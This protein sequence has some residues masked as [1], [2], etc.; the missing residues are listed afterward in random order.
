MKSLNIVSLKSFLVISVLS[1]VFLFTTSLN[2]QLTDASSPD[3]PTMVSYSFSGLLELDMGD[4]RICNP[5]N[6]P[7]I[8]SF[9]TLGFKIDGS[10]APDTFVPQQGAVY[11][12]SG[13]DVDF[14]I[15]SQR[16]SVTE[17]TL[18]LG[19]NTMKLYMEQFDKLVFTFMWDNQNRSAFDFRQSFV[20]GTLEHPDVIF[21]EWDNTHCW[22]KFTTL[23]IAV[24]HCDPIDTLLKPVI[25]EKPSGVVTYTPRELKL[26]TIDI[27]SVYES[28]SSKIAKA[29]GYVE[30]S[31]DSKYWVDDYTLTVDGSDVF[32]SEKKAVKYSGKCDGVLSIDFLYSGSEAVD[33]EVSGKSGPVASYTGVVSG[34]IIVV[35][36]SLAG[37]DKLSSNTV[38]S[39]YKTGTTMMVEEIEVHT[40]CSRPLTVGMVYGSLELVDMVVKIGSYTS[41]D[42]PDYLD[43]VKSVHHNLVTADRM[44][45]ERILFNT[46]LT[47]VQN[48]ANQAKYD[49][50]LTKSWDA[51]TLAE[52][53]WQQSDPED[54]IDNFKKAW[55]YAGKAYEYA[56]K[57]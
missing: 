34:D 32:Y 40:S 26:M 38:F 27:L 56:I 9:M 28:I 7:L 19:K 31:L 45:V 6:Y 12:I 52:S 41:L 11:F 51:Y 20:C 42:F 1:M 13:E 53:K 25:Y 23:A 24:G 18:L 15:N 29:I 37:E 36:A 47:P 49:E 10:R 57:P 48:P 30:D 44:L 14:V 54:A 55:E 5:M 43:A 46:Q 8:D 50:N 22:G 17:L 2:A 33:I 39:L 21:S 4:P 3:S 35:D 16:Q